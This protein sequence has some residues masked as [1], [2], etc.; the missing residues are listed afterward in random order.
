LIPEE[1]PGI[2]RGFLEGIRRKGEKKAPN[3]RDPTL[4]SC[5]VERA[6]PTQRAGQRRGRSAGTEGKANTVP[7][8]KKRKKRQATSCIKKGLVDMTAVEG[9]LENRR[10][11]AKG[12]TSQ[13]NRRKMRCKRTESS[14]C[15]KT[16]GGNQRKRRRD[17]G[18]KGQ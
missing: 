14:R 5:Q 15:S 11:V 3:R 6:K 12:G 9:A 1:W 16:L 18:G 7:K 13:I 8:Q 17:A 2:L 10:K 4:K